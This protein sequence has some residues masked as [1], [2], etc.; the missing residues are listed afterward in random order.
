MHAGITFPKLII[1]FSA[2]GLRSSSLFSSEIN[3]IGKRGK[4]FNAIKSDMILES[5]TST[6][7]VEGEDIF[8]TEFS[9]RVSPASN[10]RNRSG[11]QNRAS[12]RSR[13]M[14]V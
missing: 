7:R 1:K 12:K 6:I 2:V 11:F 8:S 4:V 14:R 3:R 13:L 10:G 5:V 9:C